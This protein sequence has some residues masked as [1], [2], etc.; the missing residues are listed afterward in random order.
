MDITV[1]VCMRNIEYGECKYFRSI[2][3]LFE[4][5]SDIRCCTRF[6]EQPATVEWVR[7]ELLH[8]GVASIHIGRQEFEMCGMTFQATVNKYV[9]SF[10]SVL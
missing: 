5:E 9:V 1:I 7:S 10:I 6:G 8:N 3:S 2:E 4:H